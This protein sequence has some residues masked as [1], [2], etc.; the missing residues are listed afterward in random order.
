MKKGR[1]K[2][3]KVSVHYVRLKKAGIHGTFMNRIKQ[4]LFT[5]PGSI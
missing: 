1:N 5:F 4:A 2:F 3:E